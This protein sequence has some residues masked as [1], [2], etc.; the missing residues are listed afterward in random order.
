MERKKGL[1]PDSR[2]KIR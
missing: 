1:M 2:V